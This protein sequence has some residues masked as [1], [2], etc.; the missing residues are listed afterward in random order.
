MI[1]FT[2][3]ILSHTQ[4][5]KATV[6]FEQKEPHRSGANSGELCLT[7]SNS[8]CNPSWTTWVAILKLESSVRPD[9]VS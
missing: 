4:R 5:Q 3:S 9:E 6:N 2:V 1:P 8:Y 7:T